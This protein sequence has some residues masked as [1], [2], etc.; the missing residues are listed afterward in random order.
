[1]VFKLDHVQPILF[2]W[3]FSTMHYFH[4]GPVLYFVDNVKEATPDFVPFIILTNV[5]LN[6]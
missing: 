1:L 3:S 4:N 2:F 5:R 6:N